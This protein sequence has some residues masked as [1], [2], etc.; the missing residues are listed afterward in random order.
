MSSWQCS[1][2]TGGGKSVGVMEDR[3]LQGIPHQK[4]DLL[5]TL[6]EADA[7]HFDFASLFGNPNQASNS[8]TLSQLQ[9]VSSC[10]SD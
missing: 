8:L 9:N 10:H 2:I 5:F 6:L 7:G 4:F 3:K 1:G